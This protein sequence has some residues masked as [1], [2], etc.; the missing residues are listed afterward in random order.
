MAKDPKIDKKTYYKDSSCMIVRDFLALDRT[1][2]ANERTFLAWIRTAL[3]VIGAGIGLIKLFEM[4]P[5]YTIGYIMIPLGM[6][7]FV[8]GA[9]KFLKMKKDLSNL[10]DMQE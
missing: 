9:Y 5:F 1:I 4:E 7:I 3:S 10:M 8:W 6:V 2:L